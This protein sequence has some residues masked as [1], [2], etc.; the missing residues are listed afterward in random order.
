M[1]LQQTEDNT[2]TPLTPWC[3]RILPSKL[4]EEPV[5]HGDL[6][7]ARRL[8][9]SGASPAGNDKLLTLS[10]ERKDAPMTSLLIAKGARCTSEHLECAMRSHQKG[11]FK[12]LLDR[13]ANPEPPT[14]SLLFKAIQPEYVWALKP[15]LEKGASAARIEQ[16]R[17]IF[18]LAFR[19]RVKAHRQIVL[20]QMFCYSALA[21]KKALLCDIYRKFFTVP[22]EIATL[23]LPARKIFSHVYKSSI[24]FRK[25]QLVANALGIDHLYLKTGC[26][27]SVCREAT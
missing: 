5:L 14:H 3:Q 8:I 22:S 7:W 1:K 16:G 26:L 25:A 24:P 20:Q 13:G 17:S 21:T 18:A 27:C 9:Q 10:I 15:L 2:R 6:R 12:V 19:L 11:L 4:L 23:L